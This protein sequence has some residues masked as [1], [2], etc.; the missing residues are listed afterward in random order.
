MW[1]E[2]FEFFV[3][4]GKPDSRKEWFTSLKGKWSASRMPLRRRIIFAST[5]VS[6]YFYQLCELERKS[7]EA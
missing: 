3:Y 6:H 1:L 4:R 5:S 2:G 7:G